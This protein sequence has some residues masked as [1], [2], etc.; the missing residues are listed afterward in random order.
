M[1]T[2]DSRFGFAASRLPEGEVARYV[3]LT[4]TRLRMGPSIVLGSTLEILSRVVDGLWHA[5]ALSIEGGRGF[6]PVRLVADG[7]GATVRFAD[8]VVALE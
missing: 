4:V 7:V 6:S 2:D 5:A 3:P 8:G 1:G